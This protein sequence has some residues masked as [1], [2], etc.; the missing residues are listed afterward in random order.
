MS[1]AC[2][3]LGRL[4]SAAA[5]RAAAGLRRV[6]RPR[7]S[8]QGPLADLASNDYLGLA[9][10]PRAAGNPGM[11]PATLVISDARNHASLIDA[12]RLARARVEIDGVSAGCFRPP[13]VP[14]GHSCLRLTAR[15]NLTEAG[16]AAAARA[17]A[18]VSDHVRAASP[19]GRK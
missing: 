1:D 13:S 8:Q 18:A 16:F 2:D 9:T 10:D 14:P 4:R 19:V 3:P 5:A 17:L 15:A 7:D 11:A 6:L 12:C